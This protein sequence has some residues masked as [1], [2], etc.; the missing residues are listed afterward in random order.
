MKK[1]LFV[2]VH[3]KQRTGNKH[4]YFFLSGTLPGNFFVA[5]S[6]LL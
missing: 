6:L 1:A 3:H 4:K 2:F 5:L